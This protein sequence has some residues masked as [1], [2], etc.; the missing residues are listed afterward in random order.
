[1]EYLNPRNDVA[2]KKIFGDDNNKDILLHFLNDVLHKTGNNAI[3]EVTIC[4]PTQLPEIAYNKESILD[5]LC[6]DNNG[7]K[8]IVEMQVNSR[9]G[10]EKRAQYYAAKTYSSQAKAS[11][12]YYNLKEV[13]FLAILD[14]NL[15][16]HKLNYKSDH[17]ILDKDS[18]A[19]D[20]RDFSF[21]FIELPKFNKQNPEELNSYEEKWC[22]FFKYAGELDIMRK[23]LTTI[24]DVA[25]IQKAYNVLEAHNWTSQELINYEAEEKKRKD[26][27]AREAF[28]I[29]EASAKGIEIG[30]KRGVEIGKEWGLEIGKEEGIMQFAASMKALGIDIE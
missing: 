30:K 15:F 16:P 17:V 29:D 22:Y 13:I 11:D 20:L 26:S 25:I 8:Y 4:N 9:K 14:Y 1:M 10:F 21:T 2:F 12:D 27:K 3:A 7:I 19:H 6:T 18:Y 24:K 5:V 28:I 23:F